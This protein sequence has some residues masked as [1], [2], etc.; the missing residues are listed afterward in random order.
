MFTTIWTAI[1]RRAQLVLR[2]VHRRLLAW[3]RRAPSPPVGSTVGDLP[4]TKAAL[5]AEN[6]FLRQQLLLLS[7]DCSA[8]SHRSG[9][10]SISSALR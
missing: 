9:S 6:A 4:R 3:T 10:K 8:M 7:E 1:R 2:A 5:V